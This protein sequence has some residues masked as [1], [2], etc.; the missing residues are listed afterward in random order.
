MRGTSFDLYRSAEEVYEVFRAFKIVC[1]RVWLD[2][3]S[4]FYFVS[5]S[6]DQ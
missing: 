1:V 6:N 4:I 3:K 2:R 5:I